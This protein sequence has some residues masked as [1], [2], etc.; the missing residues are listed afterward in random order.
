MC[1]RG[2]QRAVLRE[3]RV[4]LGRRVEGRAVVERRLGEKLEL[5]SERAQRRRTYVRADA[6][7]RVRLA[8][9]S[10]GVAAPRRGDL[11]RVRVM[12][13]VGIRNRV[14]V[15]VRVRLRLNR[16]LGD[17]AHHREE[18]LRQ[19]RSEVSCATPLAW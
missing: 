14:R 11:V 18:D 9:E 2:P 8:L 7:E 15:R 12:V 16:P 5:E 19:V 4:R 10:L 3:E 1:V 17:V 13:R 6:L